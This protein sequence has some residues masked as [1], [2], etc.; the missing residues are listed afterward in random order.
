MKYVTYRDGAGTRAGILDEQGRVQPLAARSVADVIA[1]AAGT[2]PLEA[3]GPALAVDGVELLAPIVRPARNVFCVGKNY[4]DHAREFAASGYDRSS[5]G[6]EEPD[7][8][9]VFT[10][11]P[12]S[13]IGDGAEIDRH[14]AVTDELDYEAELAV[15]IGRPGRDI[16]P[17][18]APAHIWG[19]T[20]VNDVTARDRQRDHKQWF[21]GKGLDT[22]C[23][24]GPWAVTA[25][26]VDPEGRG[27][28]DLEVTCRV[29]GELR[30]KASTLDLIFDIPTLIAE[31]SSGLTLEPGDV[32]A[33]GT[34]AG[35]GIGFTP[36]R[37]LDSGDEVEI[38]ITGL[39]TLHNRVAGPA[40]KGP[41]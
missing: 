22:F 41:T 35:V 6:A 10:K 25:D 27:R 8:P 33:T 40:E 34:P 37:F 11:P 21:L 32:I 19:Y 39:G 14:R 36:P 7:A 31:I 29:N 12:S 15:M 16:R 24:M 3:V 5:G 13:V 38:S 9:V 23:P 20:I 2:A 30:Q 28:P 26:E 17:E 18:D 1:A 4:R